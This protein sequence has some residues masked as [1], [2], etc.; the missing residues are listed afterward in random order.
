M[1]TERVYRS[2]LPHERAIAE[3]ERCAG[4]QFDPDIVAVFL[5]CLERGE[6]AALKASALV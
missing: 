5:S 3:L 6:I 1:T 4:S 2:K